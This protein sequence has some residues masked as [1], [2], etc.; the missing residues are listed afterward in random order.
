VAIQFIS[1][2]AN[3]LGFSRT[4]KPQCPTSYPDGLD[5]FLLKSAKLCEQTIAKRD[6]FL[7][8]VAGPPGPFDEARLREI[9]RIYEKYSF[10]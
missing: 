10:R 9:E 5:D 6:E 4:T 3:L 2:V 7:E 8:N 1:T